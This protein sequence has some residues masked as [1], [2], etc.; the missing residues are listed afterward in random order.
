MKLRLDLVFAAILVATAGSEL[1]APDAHSAPQALEQ[2]EA[3]Q[4]QP[5]RAD[6]SDGTTRIEAA[7]R[8]IAYGYSDIT[9]LAKG[10][11]DTWH[12]VAFA[13]GDPVSVV[14]TPDGTVLTE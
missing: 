13:E 3:R 10:C 4:A 5:C 12:A 1:V 11:G 2:E 14:V 6:A 9:E 8:I 7:E